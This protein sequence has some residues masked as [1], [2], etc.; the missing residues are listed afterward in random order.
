MLVKMSLNNGGRTAL[1]M[2]A[3]KKDD[4]LLWTLIENDPSNVDLADV[5]RRTPL[6]FAAGVGSIFG[7]EALLEHGADVDAQ[8]MSGRTPLSWAAA[9]GHTS[10]AKIL[11]QNN[12]VQSE[13][14]DIWGKT[15]LIYACISGHADLVALLLEYN[16]PLII[17]SDNKKMSPLA[18]A[19]ANGHNAVIEILLTL[20]TVIRDWTL[21]G[22]KEKTLKRAAK[23]R[24]AEEWDLREHLRWDLQYSRMPQTHALISHHR[25]TFKLLYKHWRA[26]KLSAQAHLLPPLPHPSPPSPTP[27]SPSLLPLPSIS[28]LSPLS[29]TLS[30][31]PLLRTAI[32]MRTNVVFSPPERANPGENEPWDRKCDDDDGHA[33]EERF[34]RAELEAGYQRPR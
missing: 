25:D 32:G 20:E 31:L 3:E 34:K 2:A 21:Q 30:P 29:S 11:L 22:W 27:P 18:H 16:H 17:K 7:I 19:A 8:D 28:L 23:A 4:P 13:S 24:A 12:N 5:N 26:L 9:G 10:A 15:P 6:S 14:A 1:S 33:A